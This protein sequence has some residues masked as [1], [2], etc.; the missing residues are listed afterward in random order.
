MIQ[1]TTPTLT[2]TISDTIDLTDAQDVL[3]TFN[4]RGTALTKHMGEN[5]WLI[6][7]NVIALTLTQEE[8]LIFTPGFPVEVQ[9]NW[10]DANDARFATIKANVPFIENLIPEVIR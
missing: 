5:M 6:S 8:T 10:I 3:I 2:F 9:A 7:P 1:A 4:Q